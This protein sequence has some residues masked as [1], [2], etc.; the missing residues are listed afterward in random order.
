M[1]P[2]L[3][4]CPPHSLASR[5]ESRPAVASPRAS[6]RTPSPRASSPRAPS[7]RAGAVA[8]L[9]QR[10]A[11]FGAH[12]DRAV[13]AP[14]PTGWRGVDRALGGGLAP[15]MLHEWFG[16][17]RSE[18][19]GGATRPPLL[20]L[21][22]LAHRAL[23]LRAA[24]LHAPGLH[25]SGLHASGAPIASKVVWI[26]KAVR[27]S[28][29]PTRVVSPEDSSTHGHDTQDHD[30]QD[31]DAHGH[32]HDRRRRRW[33]EAGPAQDTCD[34]EALL[35]R[36]IFVDPPDDRARLWAI[37]LCLRAPSVAVVV[38]D[39]RGLSMA[40]SR[41]LQLA[42][43]AGNTLAL[44]ARPAAE[45]RTLSAAATRWHVHRT[46]VA[47]RDASRPRWMLELLRCKGRARGTAARTPRRR[48]AQAMSPQAMS[49]QAGTS[50]AA[51]V[52]SLDALRAI[53]DFYIPS[54]E[55]QRWIV[56]WNG[57]TG[58]VSELSELVDRS[59]GAAGP[60]ATTPGR[61]AASA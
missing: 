33:I 39:G 20:L 49:L 34:D 25:T 52:P 50:R 59:V 55:A 4:P 11:L 28:C 40:A 60:A 36:S 8:R 12:P 9:A 35:A 3:A 42:A 47:E 6:S 45:R 27:P 1:P 22:H 53:A 18:G 41:R 61:S 10:F 31:H 26:G 54:T 32:E 44:L 16:P 56:E 29:F 24:T 19:G 2:H 17:E 48:V 46:L 23:A 21:T 51:D 30:A 38:A 37:D 7:P 43:E 13:A 57:A 15:G 14:I 58:V 5:A